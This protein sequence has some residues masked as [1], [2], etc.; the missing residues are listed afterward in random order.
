MRTGLVW[1]A[2]GLVLSSAVCVAQTGGKTKDAA[3]EPAKSEAK[4]EDETAIREAM[5]AQAEAWNRSDI[6]G[7]MRAYE[8]SP[9]TT[10]IGQ[11]LRKGYAPILEQ[12]KKAYT[13]HAQMGTLSFSDLDVR[14]LAGSCGKA[15]FAVVTGKFHLERSMRGTAKKDD[16]TFSLV[17]RNGPEGW[18][19]VLDHTS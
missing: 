12:Y 19:I 7:F 13:N 5:A 3:R 11:T 18:K 17:W 4:N 2:L 8:N 16:G 14:L 15:E 1:M 10:F 9:E 6:P